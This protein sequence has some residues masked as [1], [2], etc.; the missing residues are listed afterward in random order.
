MNMDFFDFL[1]EDMGNE[2][3]FP[4]EGLSEE[5]I[6]KWCTDESFTELERWQYLLDK[7]FPE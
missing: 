7:G 3:E 1:G 5:E 2:P 6:A 4:L